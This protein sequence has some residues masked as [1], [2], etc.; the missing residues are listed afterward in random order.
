MRSEGI[1][2]NPMMRVEDCLGCFSHD[3]EGDRGGTAQGTTPSEG[4]VQAGAHMFL[5][6]SKMGKE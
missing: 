1:E 2:S 5:R 3:L 6:L 4:A